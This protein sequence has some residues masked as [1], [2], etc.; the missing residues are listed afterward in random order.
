MKWYRRTVWAGIWSGGIVGPYF[1]AGTVTGE[2]YFDML[3]EAVLPEL[4]DIPL[5]DNTEIIRQQEGAPPHYRLRV[6]EFLNNSF[7]RGT[8]DPPPFR[9]CDLTP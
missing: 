5:Y 6:R 8:V 1:F 7:R 9:S 4:E 3:R 2:S